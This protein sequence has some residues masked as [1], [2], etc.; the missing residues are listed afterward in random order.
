MSI[1]NDVEAIIE[2]RKGKVEQLQSRKELLEKIISSLEKLQAHS[3]KP[4][5]DAFR[6]CA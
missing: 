5:L 3:S 6:P 1:A 2:R 4:L